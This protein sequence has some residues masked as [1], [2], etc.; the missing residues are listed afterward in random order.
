MKKLTILTLIY[1]SLPTVVFLFS[2]VETFVSVPS[3]ILLLISLVLSIKYLDTKDAHLPKEELFKILISS[4]ILSIALC[5]FSEFGILPFQSSD[6][7][8][9]YLKLGILYNEN[10]PIYDKEREVYM[11]YYLGQ[12]IIPSF[13]AKITSVFFLK[14]YFFLWSLIG[15]FLAF[16]WIQIKL[17][18]LSQTK[19]ILICSSLIV[20]SY[21]CII[22]PVINYL[23]PD[24]LT[25][26]DNAINI[27]GKFTLSQISIFTK[28]LSE[29][30]QHTVPSVLGIS[31]LLATWKNTLY[32]PSLCFFALG[33]IFCTPFAAIG[34]MPFLVVIFLRIY[35]ERGLSFLYDFI[36]FLIPLLLSFIAVIIFLLSSQATNMESNRSI[37]EIGVSHNFVY[38][39]TYLFVFYGIWLIIFNKRLF[40]FDNDALLVSII[41]VMILSLFQMGYYNDL[42]MR[43]SVVPQIVFGLSIGYGIIV[44]LNTIFKDGFLIIG[45]LFWLFNTISPIKFYYERIFVMNSSE[46]VDQLSQFEPLNKSFYAYLEKAYEDNP[47]EVVKQYSLK[48]SSIFE[49]YLLDK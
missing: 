46:I 48:K 20:G 13:L 29:A 25:I 2:W 4:M 33:S 16:S 5:S 15:V 11:C 31:F 23:F 10:S 35:R 40:E 39:V 38:Y 43:A 27:D 26:R 37:W 9:H 3:I 21:V 22:F 18:Q 24:L 41:F 49:K 1:I 19:R 12:Y 44:R 28:G 47:S 36:L 14:I 45:V 34:L 42:I 32:F 30:P 6:Y 8:G 17:I 7:L